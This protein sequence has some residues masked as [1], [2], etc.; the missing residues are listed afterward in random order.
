M[1]LLTAGVDEAGRGPLAAP[2]V[3][4]A[5]ILD[6]ARRPPA[7]RDSKVLNPARRLTLAL[8]RC[9]LCGM[10]RRSFAPVKALLVAQGEI[11]GGG[12][13]R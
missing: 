4:A 10:H 1:G 5:V 2:V 3:A 13:C 12:L 7:V 11:E 6:R 8:R 9:G